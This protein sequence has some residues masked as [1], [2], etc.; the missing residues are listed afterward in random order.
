[1]LVDEKSLAGSNLGDTFWIGATV[2]AKLGTVQLDGAIV[3]GQRQIARA[4]SAGPGSPFSES[5]YGAFVSAQVPVGPVNV[6]AVGWYTSGD[7]H[8]RPGGLR[9]SG[10][11][12]RAASRRAPRAR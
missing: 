1:M 4:V 7:C 11:D 8:G 6:F 10:H 5:G 3:Y 2:G 9:G 12:L